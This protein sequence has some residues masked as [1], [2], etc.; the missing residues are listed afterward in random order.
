MTGTRTWAVVLASVGQS[1]DVRARTRTA[2]TSVLVAPMREPPEGRAARPPAVVVGPPAA[3]AGRLA[4]PR[5]RA[6]RPG[7]RAVRPGARGHRWIR[8]ADAALLR[9][10][11]GRDAWRQ[12]R[13][14]ALAPRL[15]RQLA[16]RLHVRIES[17]FVQDLVE[18]VVE[19]V[20]RR[21]GHPLGLYEQR[22]LLRPSPSH[23]HAPTLFGAI[24][25][26]DPLPGYFNGLLGLASCSR[27]SSIPE[28]P[29]REH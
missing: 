15:E 20:P 23:R 19:P 2:R 5:A 16:Q 21:P 24:H 28:W 10:E 6:V 18:R 7:A 11:E 25:R 9:L 29:L 3:P 14:T 8:W 22:S 13:P 26:V 27:R 1:P 12:R 17:C 4:A